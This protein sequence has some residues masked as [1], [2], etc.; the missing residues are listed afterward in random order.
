MLQKLNQATLEVRLSMNLEKT[1]VMYDEFTENVEEPNTDTAN[2]DSN[3]I[4]EVVTSTSV[5]TSTWIPP[6]RNKRS[7]VVS[8]SD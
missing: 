3:K 4:D 5:N 2:T 8:P 7:N 1:K 6:R